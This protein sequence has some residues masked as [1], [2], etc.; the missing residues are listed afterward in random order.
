MPIQIIPRI[1]IHRRT[2]RRRV[3]RLTMPKAS[4][5]IWQAM[6]TLVSARPI[7]VWTLSQIPM[8]R[9]MAN[10]VKASNPRGVEV[11]ATIWSVC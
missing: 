1:R 2:N 5:T 3:R 9:R 11:Q 6:K 10:A 7:V 4:N 8:H